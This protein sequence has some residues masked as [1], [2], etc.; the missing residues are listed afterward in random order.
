MKFRRI[1]NVALGLMVFLFLFV[2]F[3]DQGFAAGKKDPACRYEIPLKK[4]G[5]ILNVPA[6][7]LDI[8][9]YKQ[10]VSPDDQKNKTYKVP[11][12]GY[13]YR[14][15]SDFLKSISYTVYDFSRPEKARS[16]FETMKGNFKTVAK[17]ETVQGL[18]D[19]AFWVNDKRFHRFVCLKGG[20]MID[21]LRPKELELQKRVVRL[22][23]GK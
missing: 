15:K 12:C 19:A 7:D 1:Q 6:A 17:V 21:V 9:S 22:L 3:V 14:S 23:L 5:T 8:R 4:A 11:P 16:V 13:S 18:G 10:P 2:G 20:L